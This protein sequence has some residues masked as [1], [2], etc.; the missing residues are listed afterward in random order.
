MKTEGNIFFSARNAVLKSSSRFL[1]GSPMQQKIMMM[2]IIYAYDNNTIFY[3]ISIL[4][5]RIFNLLWD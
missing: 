4:R 1:E 2:I 3:H 5:M